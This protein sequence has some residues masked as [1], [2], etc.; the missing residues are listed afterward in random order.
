[1]VCH[2]RRHDRVP[3]R[4]RWL[5]GIRHVLGIGAL[6]RIEVVDL[7]KLHEMLDRRVPFVLWHALALVTERIRAVCRSLA[8][9]AA[10]W[11]H[12]R[13]TVVVGDVELKRVQREHA[14]AAD[15]ALVKEAH[16]IASL[17]RNEQ[18]I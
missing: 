1:M 16:T 10:P 18:V 15:L 13:S 9:E 7:A 11:L 17:Y 8:D 4:A 5:V 3:V 14:C 6:W 12:W 2:Q